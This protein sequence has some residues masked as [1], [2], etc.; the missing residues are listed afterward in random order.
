MLP[1]SRGPSGSRTADVRGSQEC[2]GVAKL[3]IQSHLVSFRLIPLVDAGG[4]VGGALGVA[5]SMGFNP[6]PSP[7]PKGRGDQAAFAGND[8]GLNLGS[9][10]PWLASFTPS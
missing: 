3:I 6:H 7:L 2:V 10:W 8:G 4:G 5:P 1:E 9:I